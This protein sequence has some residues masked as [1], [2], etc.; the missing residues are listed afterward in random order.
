MFATI[1]K[2]LKILLR[3][4]VGFLL[5]LIMPGILIIVMATTQ[6]SSYKDL[7]DVEFEVAIANLDKGTVGASIIKAIDASDKFSV[8]VISDTT[9]FGARVNNGDIQI[10]VIIP[11]NATAALTNV[12][13][14]IANSL[15][16]ASGLPASFAQN[17][18]LD[19]VSIAL[20]F[21]PTLKPAL[22]NGFR[23]ALTQ[24]TTQAKMDMLMQRLSNMAGA[25]S[26]L[27]LSLSNQMSSVLAL[28]ESKE[29]VFGGQNM[30][31]NSVQHNVPSWAIFA[32]F[33]IVVPIAGNLL[34]E[35]EEGSVTRLKLIPDAMRKSTFGT[36]AFYVMVCT[37][38]FYILILIGIYL[39]PAFGLPKL[40]MGP[41]PM[42]SL[43]LVLA[44]A[45][46]A[47]AYGFFIGTAFKTANQAMPIGAVSVVILAALGGIWVPLE[48]LPKVMTNI[49]NFTP[50]YWSFN[51]INN[52]FV[53]GHGFA[54]TLPSIAL[55]TVFG[56]VLSVI[57]VLIANKRTVA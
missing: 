7:Q 33:L 23:F 26:N 31:L 9:G 8:K 38:Q 32:M 29:A 30:P 21:D 4:P 35:R 6:D 51:G 17:K 22:K 44:T 19:S 25:E 24:Y 37:V 13:N 27:N 52:L 47:T 14:S 2:E 39:L 1:L 15:S 57:C 10:G 54:A 49:A 34:R 16:G 40:A 42:H 5:L 46:A 28:D 48:I 20:L 41:Y 53:R 11:A 50:L 55:L 12:S 36:L 18:A 56:L 3:D 45:F 43:P